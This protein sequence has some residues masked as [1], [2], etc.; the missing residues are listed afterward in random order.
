MKHVGNETVAPN[1]MCSLC[2]KGWFILFHFMTSVREKKQQPGSRNSLA[3]IPL[4]HIQMFRILRSFG[5]SALKWHCTENW[6]QIFPEMKLCSLVPNSYIHVSVSDLYFPR[7]GLPIRLH[8]NKW[9]DR[10][11]IYQS[12][13]ETRM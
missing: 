7:I 10:G 3:L 13:T 6:K 9:T 5:D 8:Q 4:T 11:N 1:S 2:E 12:L